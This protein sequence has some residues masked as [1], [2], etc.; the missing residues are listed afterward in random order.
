MLRDIERRMVSALDRLTPPFGPGG[1]LLES[2]SLMP[3]PLDVLRGT[4]HLESFRPGQEAVVEGQMQGRDVLSVAPTGSGKS[5][6]YWV[7]AL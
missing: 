1:A 7:P 3:A 4:F 5:I 6:S 2:A